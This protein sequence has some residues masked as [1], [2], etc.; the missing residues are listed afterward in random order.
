MSNSAF[1]LKYLAIILARF[2]GY[3]LGRAYFRANRVP[4]VPA[5]ITFDG[6][7]IGR[8]GIDDPE[9]TNHHTHPARNTCRFVN[10]YE[11]RLR[12]PPH[13]SIGARIQTRRFDTMPALQGQILALHIH[14]GHRLRFFL[15]RSGKLFGKGCDFRCAP[16]FALVASG[17][18]FG[19]Y[20]YNL[21]FIL[22]TKKG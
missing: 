7:L 11:F 10:V 16:Q 15:N 12:I 4:H 19:V 8:R 6:H 5:A 13:G 2:H 21:Q 14:P 17:T 1:V 3:G 20:L 9:G 18:F 22:L